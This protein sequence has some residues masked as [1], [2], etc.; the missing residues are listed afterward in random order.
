MPRLTSMVAAALVA[1]TACAAP[2]AAAAAP[3][4][5]PHPT[6]GAEK[7]PL[8]RGGP[9][10]VGLHPSSGAPG[11]KVFLTD[12]LCADKATATSRALGRVT[13]SPGANVLVG[14]AT[15]RKVAPGRYPVTFVCRDGRTGHSHFTVAGTGAHGRRPS[16][17][18]HAGSGGTGDPAGG[19]DL[20]AAA[21]LATAAAGS[22][23]YA[24]RRRRGASGVR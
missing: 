13:L 17:P 20:A 23:L 4:P 11:K 14:E 2:V 16:G 7:G 3:T 9:G 19:R 21:A 6:I 22:V 5:P 15:V 8:T 10:G 24:G 1:G 18:V 12:S